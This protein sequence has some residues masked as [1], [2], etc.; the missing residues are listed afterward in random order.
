MN[1]RLPAS[2]L[3]HALTGLTKVIAPNATLPV[4][5]GVCIEAQGKTVTLT[6]TDLDT[7]ATYTCQSAEVQEPG[8]TVIADSKRLKA[9]VQSAKNE[10]A[11]LRILNEDAMEIGL[12]G[13]KGD[14][15]H[16]LVTLPRG[17]FPDTPHDIKTAPVDKLFL[18][19][20]RMLLPFSSTDSTRHTLESVCCEASE[21]GTIM[22]STDGRR[23]TT[24]NS[25]TL[26]L[27]KTVIL[28][29]NKFLAWPQLDG[30][31]RIGV[32]SKHNWMRITCGVWDATVRTIEG[33]YPNWRQVVP[34][35]TDEATQ[36]ILASADVPV[37][38][39]AIKTLPGADHSTKP[40]TIMTGTPHP[41]IAACDPESGVWS[42][43]VLAN[44]S[45]NGE[46]LG[47]TV[48]RS[49]LADAVKAG[50]RSFQIMD[51][52]C[53]LLARDNDNTHVLMPVRGSF[54]PELEEELAK[55]KAEATA[56]DDTTAEPTPSPESEKKEETE[57]PETKE[58]N[59]MIQPKKNGPTDEQPDLWTQYQTIKEKA[60]D[61]NCAIAELGQSIK[62]FH[63]EQKTVRVE[64]DNAR[65]VLAKLQS[66]NI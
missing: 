10:E 24:A 9:I 18:E 16:V 40:V 32:H 26:P 17:E 14:R 28:P 38:L 19:H 48:N 55:R 61:L 8:A 60:R 42:Y 29:R 15:L 31:T 7:F 23:L 41:R 34:G 11:V 49:Y 5:R 59:R 63:K 22:V 36:F 62:G 47:V 45:W 66:I 2:E 20:Y 13:P 46:A 58:N 53:P 52:L 30:E 3:A 56:G 54:P 6:G 44:S 37:L 39:D 50:F 27:D 21:E 57:E 12:H 25:I 51:E 64:L 35:Y 65:G 43:Q 4:L 1:I 33:T